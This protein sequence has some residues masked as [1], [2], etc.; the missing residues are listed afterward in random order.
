MKCFDS[1]NGDKMKDRY[2][3]PEMEI[4]E[5]ECEDIITTSSLSPDDNND[6][7]VIKLPFILYDPK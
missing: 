5:F 4:I 3:K 1:V 6:N 7:G 2:I